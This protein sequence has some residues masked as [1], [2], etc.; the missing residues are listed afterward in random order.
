MK[1]YAKTSLPIERR[2][3]ALLAELTVEEQ[4]RRKRR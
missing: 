3:D 2:I 4:L 1:T